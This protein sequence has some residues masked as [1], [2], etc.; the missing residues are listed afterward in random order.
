MTW[1]LTALTSVPIQR[2]EAGALELLRESLLGLPAPPTPR[3][4][5]SL[6]DFLRRRPSVRRAAARQRPHSRWRA[7]L[8]HLRDRTG[9][10]A[11]HLALA[12]QASC[13]G[14]RRGV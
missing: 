9:V 2:G 5:G 10:T 3:S 13:S 12:A 1:D 7:A 4:P 6:I 8:G 14:A 11:Q